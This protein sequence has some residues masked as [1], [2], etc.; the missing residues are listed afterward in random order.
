MFPAGVILVF[1][2]IFA[3]FVLVSGVFIHKKIKAKKSKQRF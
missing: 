1:C 2:L 3:A